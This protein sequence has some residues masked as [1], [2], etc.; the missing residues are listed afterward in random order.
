MTFDG[1]GLP[2]G[3]VHVL[4]RARTRGAVSRSRAV[5]PRHVSRTLGFVAVTPAIFSPNG[6]GRN[7]VLAVD[8]LAH[9]ACRRPHP[10]RA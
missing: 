6:D 9:G 7:D 10:V 5:V 2:D 3:D 1:A 4:L 8:V